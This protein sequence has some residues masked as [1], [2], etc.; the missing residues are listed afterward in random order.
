M[1][2]A[3]FK[4]LLIESNFDKERMNIAI[5]L[6]TEFNDFLS[7]NKQTVQ[8]CSYED[9]YQFSNKMIDSNSNDYDNYIHI[10]RYARFIDNK[11]LIIAIME[12]VDGAEMIENFAERLE[13]QY[14][15][16]IKDDV[17]RVSG[18][19]PLGIHPKD[20]PIITMGL[21]DRLIENISEKRAQKFL[22]EGL[23]DK[24]ADWYKMAREK[25]LKAGSL[26]KFLEVKKQNFK[27]TL[28]THM[29]DQSLFFTQK[30]DEDVMNYVSERSTIES[31]TR[32]GNIL[33][34]SKIPYMTKQFLEAKKNNDKLKMKYFYCH[35]P[36][37]REGILDESIEINPICCQISCGYYKD[38]WEGVLEKPVQVELTGSVLFGDDECTFD[39]HLPDDVIH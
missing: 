26:D 5:N 28:M 11:N 23:R 35:N 8:K 24:Y 6:I 36:W 29:K 15:R 4:S 37:F 17:F 22:N 7:K 39:I 30:I 12:I 18:I 19:P 27:Q 32:E 25:Y 13:K 1:D 16:L 10:L 20:R 3:K 9:F 14:G 34:V 2:L 21:V 38:Y 33:T 31:G